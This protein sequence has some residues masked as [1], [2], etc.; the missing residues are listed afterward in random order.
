MEALSA[1]EIKEKLTAAQ[2]EFGDC[3]E[4]DE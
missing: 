2:V 3:F 4:K 1:R